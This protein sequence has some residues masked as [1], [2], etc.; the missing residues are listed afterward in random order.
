MM[1][2]Y[3]VQISTLDCDPRE[4][5]EDEITFLVK[6]RSLSHITLKQHFRGRLVARFPMLAQCHTPAKFT[7][8]LCTNAFEESDYA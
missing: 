6:A 5:L 3:W 2:S 1:S 8:N 7:I 4:H